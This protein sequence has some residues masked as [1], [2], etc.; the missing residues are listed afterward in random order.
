MSFCLQSSSNIKWHVSWAVS[1]LLW[2]G[3]HHF[4]DDSV[5]TEEVVKIW[6]IVVVLSVGKGVGVGGGGMLG[7]G[8]EPSVGVYRSKLTLDL[9]QSSDLAVTTSWGSPVQS[10]MDLGKNDICIIVSCRMGCRSCRCCSFWSSICC[11]MSN[12]YMWYHWVRFCLVW[13]SWLTRN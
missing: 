8:G 12:I 1:L 9:K 2:S 3:Q 7:V 5:A 6:V 13:P 11:L 4:V 10:G